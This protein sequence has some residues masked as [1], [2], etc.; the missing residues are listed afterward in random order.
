LTNAIELQ[1]LRLENAAVLDVGI[2]PRCNN[3]PSLL[4]DIEEEKV[5]DD[6]VANTEVSTFN[7]FIANVIKAAFPPLPPPLD[8]VRLLFIILLILYNNEGR[9]VYERSTYINMTSR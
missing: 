8:I 1:P 6:V 7:K 5:D 3:L 9:L 2:P 4:F